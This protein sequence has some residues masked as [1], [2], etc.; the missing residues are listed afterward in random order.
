[1]KKGI[2]G[3]KLGMTQIFDE[4]GRVIPVTVIEAGPCVVIQKKTV[5]N[6]GYN[7]IKVGF[8][9]KKVRVLKVKKYDV[10]KKQD[11]KLITEQKESKKYNMPKPL[12]GIFDKI[13]I[14]YKKLVKELRLEDIAQYEV[15]QELKADVF[16]PGDKVDVIGVSKGKG[17]Q[18]VIKRYNGKRG[19]MSHGSNYHRRPGSMGGSASPSRVFKNKKLPGHMGNEKVTVQN[20][21]VVK[22]DIEK[23]IM[24]IK[25]AI[26]G[27]KGGY[28]VIKDSIKASK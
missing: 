24:L 6:D 27:P 13:K 19:P 14:P 16:K 18:G 10:T 26:P 9:D 25:G 12:K 2:L 21:D 7:S 15:G 5:Q 17:F 8:E 22:V 4:V 1:M 20:L 23:N 11:G 28:V 3:K